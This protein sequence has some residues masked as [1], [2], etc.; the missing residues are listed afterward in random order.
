MRLIFYVY[1]PYNK[2][3]YLLIYIPCSGNKLVTRSASMDGQ[4]QKKTNS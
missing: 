4:G 2:G 3:I 1:A